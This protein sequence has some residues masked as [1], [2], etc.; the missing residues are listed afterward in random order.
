MTR[1]PSNQRWLE[2]RS[3]LVGDTL[4]RPSTD[5]YEVSMLDGKGSDTIAKAFVEAHHYSGSYPAAR[6]RAILTRRGELVGVAVFSQPCSEVVLA[7]LPCDRREAVE[8]GR[9]VLLDE[10]PGNGE[11]W[12]LARA[13]D[14][15]RARG[16][17]ALLS[18]SDPLPRRALSGEV[19]LAGHVGQIYQ[20]TNAVYAGRSGRELHVLKPDGTILSPRAMTKIR[21][22]ERGYEGAIEQLTDIG[23][24]APTAD[25][26]ATRD[27]RRAWMWRAIF[28]TCRRLSHPGNHRYLWAI[29]KRLRRD[30]AALASGA[31]YPK[32]V[33]PEAVLTQGAN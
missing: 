3:T 4:I 26:L 12:F 30:I 13:L 2:R 18:H 14:L 33:D 24:D 31:P 9:F 1:A 32:T 7:P 27:A 17:R 5:G 25:D 19:V 6:E 11:S 22:L 29:D 8:L 15:L 10:V 28:S 20:A 21:K 16:Y 23:A